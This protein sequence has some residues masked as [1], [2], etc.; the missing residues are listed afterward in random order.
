MATG[1]S[2]APPVKQP[3]KR[4]AFISYSRTQL[5]EFWSA[6]HRFLQTGDTSRLK[7]FEGKSIKDA[8]GTEIPLPTDRKVFN[9]LASA[10]VLSF[11]SLYARSTVVV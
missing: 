9:R 4:R 11:E 3:L 10:G 1:S 8:N 6:V 7:K 5:A 2:A